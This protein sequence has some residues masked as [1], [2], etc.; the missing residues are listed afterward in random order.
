[1]TILE[2]SQKHLP[3]I[4]RLYAEVLDKGKVLSIADAEIIFDKIS[5]YPNYKAYVFE[6]DLGLTHYVSKFADYQR[7]RGSKP[8]LSE[9]F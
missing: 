5:S 8:L 7:R 6:I 1:M 3:Q 2:A 9:T 4:L